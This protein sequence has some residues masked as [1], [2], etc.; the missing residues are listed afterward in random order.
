MLKII[1]VGLSVCDE[2]GN[3]P[4]VST[5][6]FNFTFNLSLVDP[7]LQDIQLIRLREDMYAPDSIELLKNSG[8]D[9]KRNEEEGIDAEYFGELLITSGLVLFENIKWL[10]FHS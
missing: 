3:S 10:T 4:E 7:V 6:Q 8:I 5:W 9:F 1:Q 2:D